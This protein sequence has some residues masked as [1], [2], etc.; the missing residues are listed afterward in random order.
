MGEE[1][2]KGIGRQHQ[3]QEYPGERPEDQGNEWNSAA[4]KG[5][6]RGENL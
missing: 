4:A 3:V 1:K 5:G 6:E 2:G